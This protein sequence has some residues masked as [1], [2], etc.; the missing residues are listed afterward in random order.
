MENE[1]F[2]E[3]DPRIPGQN[4]VC[5]SVINPEKFTK[6]KEVFFATK[7]MQ[8]VFNDQERDTTEFRKK[9]MDNRN[10][11]YNS[12][13]E[14]YDDWKFTREQEL[15]DEFHKICDYQTTMRS[16]KI[17][18]TYDTIR[19]AK[20]KAALLQRN[21]PSFH[22]F[23][24]QVGYWLPLMANPQQ[25]DDQEYVNKELNTLMGNYKQNIEQRDVLY[26]QMKEDRL[27]EARKEVA[28]KKR[29]HREKLKKEQEREP[30]KMENTTGKIGQLRD[31]LNTVDENVIATE[32]KK[33]ENT[34][35]KLQSSEEPVTITDITLEEEGGATK[36]DLTTEEHTEEG[37]ATKDELP[38]LAQQIENEYAESQKQDEQSVNNFSAGNME[39]LEKIDPWLQRKMDQKN[40]EQ[41]NQ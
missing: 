22:V 19:E 34:H 15:E 30:E 2:L 25:I 9:M 32:K 12:I 1:D 35:Q 16:I 7:Y 4:Y 37:G 8:Y 21:D 36:D 31:L 39:N 11:S 28:R 24:G 10:I 14:G 29:E 41:N 20:K 6:Q 33:F 5:L 40:A 18:G 26:Q 3:V 23:V 27:E 13:K 17:R 38:T